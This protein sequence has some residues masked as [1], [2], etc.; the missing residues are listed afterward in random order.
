LKKKH[1]LTIEIDELN[2]RIRNFTHTE[3]NDVKVLLWMLSYYGSS[4]KKITDAT[5]ELSAYFINKNNG[6]LNAGDFEVDNISKK[7]FKNVF[8]E[9]LDFS[10]GSCDTKLWNKYS[11]FMGLTDGEGT[12]EGSRY[13]SRLKTLHS[14]PVGYHPLKAF[15]CATALSCNRTLNEHIRLF[16]EKY[17]EDVWPVKNELLFKTTKRLCNKVYESG[18]A[19]DWSN[20]FAKRIH[21]LTKD[22]YP[23]KYFTTQIE[24]FVQQNVTGFVSIQGEVS[25]GKS[26]IVASEVTKWT[27]HESTITAYFFAEFGTE[28]IYIESFVESLLDCF[29]PFLEIASFR[30]EFNEQKWSSDERFF[31]G[32]MRRFIEECGNQAKAQSKK[33]LIFI[34]DIDNAKSS[35]T[36]KG[37]NSFFIPFGL[38]FNVFFIT[39]KTRSDAE[40]FVGE[41][42]K[43]TLKINGG[44]DNHYLDVR[45]YIEN[46]LEELT[47]RAKETDQKLYEKT[48]ISTFENKFDV[49]DLLRKSEGR[50]IYLSQIFKSIEHFN[51]FDFTSPIG[52][53]GYHETLYHKLKSSN[54]LSYKE[55]LVLRALL[56]FRSGIPLTWLTNFGDGE[57][58][59]TEAFDILKSWER[60]GVVDISSYN[61]ITFARLFSEPFREFIVKNKIKEL[62]CVETTPFFRNLF[63]KML[64][65]FDTKIEE[66]IDKSIDICIFENFKAVMMKSLHANHPNSKELLEVLYSNKL[67]RDVFLHLNA[68]HALKV[69]ESS[70]D[71]ISIA[72]AFNKVMSEKNLA[73]DLL[74]LRR[75]ECHIFKQDECIIRPDYSADEMSK[76]Q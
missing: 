41:H 76:Y 15:I 44:Q 35:E 39:T 23:R 7:A 27:N 38:F 37:S 56:V 74:E 58:T 72:D 31:Q 48:S 59:Q 66:L 42:P 68:S 36:S 24:H 2:N 20:P 28:Y 65:D 51:L 70:D 13:V 75:L 40:L 10:I 55:L 21:S 1:R 52:L 57:Y 8:G 14:T 53:T 61:K 12:I 17:G 54:Q 71:S 49:E 22:Y 30:A 4:A 29:E 69:I 62:E 46:K 73:N 63:L 64:S 33:I 18:R 67:E 25:S 50:F 6:G 45:G 26:S 32:F 60:V 34:D 11:S 3:H 5:P 16:F 43:L 19:S 47:I 9:F